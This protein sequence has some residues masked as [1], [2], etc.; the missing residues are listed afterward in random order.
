MRFFAIFFAGFLGH[1]AISGLMAMMAFGAGMR[2]F[3]YDGPTGSNEMWSA[4]YIWNCGYVAADALLEKYAPL[5]PSPSPETW[6]PEYYAKIE[7]R[8]SERHNFFIL[9]AAMFGLT[10]GVVDRIR[11]R[12]KSK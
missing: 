3:T 6:P 12:R 2:S 8:Q 9:W 1:L 5:P 10:I 4:F 11:S 7:K